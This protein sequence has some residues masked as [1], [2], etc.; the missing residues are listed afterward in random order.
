MSSH[1]PLLALSVANL[2]AGMMKERAGMPH[3]VT[4]R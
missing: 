4:C 1:V 2:D 3:T